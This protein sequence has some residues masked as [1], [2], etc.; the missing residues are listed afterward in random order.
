M[1]EIANI[2]LD[3][4]RTRSLLFETVGSESNTKSKEPQSMQ[5]GEGKIPATKKRIGL[6][7]EIACHMLKAQGQRILA[8]FSGRNHIHKTRCKRGELR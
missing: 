2:T 5:L 3:T 6:T 4:S 1:A 7:Y 8:R